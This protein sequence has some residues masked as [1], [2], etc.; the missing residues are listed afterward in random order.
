M[1][2]RGPDSALP[3][4]LALVVGV[5]LPDIVEPMPDHDIAYV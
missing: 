5:D 2:T 3:E 1:T 4:G